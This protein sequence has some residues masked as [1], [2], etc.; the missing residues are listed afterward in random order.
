MQK[1]IEMVKNKVDNLNS[2]DKE[3]IYT[4]A[5]IIIGIAVLFAIIFIWRSSDVGAFCV[6]WTVVGTLCLGCIA[7]VIIAGYLA[8]K[9][10]KS[11]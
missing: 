9:D 8:Y 4:V 5:T 10:W 3:L 7:V 2:T 1:L 6:G 11:D